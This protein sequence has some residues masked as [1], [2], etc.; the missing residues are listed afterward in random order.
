MDDL[1][2]ASIVENIQVAIVHLFERLGAGLP[3]L[4]AAIAVLVAFGLVAVV[5]RRVARYGSR[6]IKNPMKA[7]LIRLVSYYTVWLIGIFVALDVMGVDARSLVTGLGLGGVALG[8]A[9]KDVLS[10]LVSGLF[11]LIAQTFEIG[12]QIVV[13]ETEGTVERIQIRATHIR[14]YDGR[15]VLVPNGEVFMSRV[16]N[17]TASDLRRTSV[18]V[19]LEY[20]QDVELAMSVILKTVLDVPGVAKNPA[21]SIRLR[22]LTTEHFYIETRF[23]TDSRRTRL[24][25]VASDVRVAIINALEGAGIALPNPNQL[26]VSMQKSSD[27]VAE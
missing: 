17:N 18:F 21:A 27:Q 20:N 6:F 4:L 9:L 12:D 26:D 2:S 15:L 22:D 25:L 13:G 7:S 8:F 1:S 19:Y 3:L 14:T 23:W 5:V 11:I 24:R 10:N 16:T